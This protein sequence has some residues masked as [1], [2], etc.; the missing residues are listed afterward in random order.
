MQK[1]RL[2]LRPILGGLFFL[3]P[4]ATL[5]GAVETHGARPNVLIVLIDDHPFNLADVDQPSPVP[6]PNIRRIAARGTWF[7]NGYCDAP[8]CGPS[9]TALLTGVH[10]ARSGVYYNQQAYR[11]NTAFISKAI[12]LPGHFLAHG[13]LTA[14]YG[15]V[16]HNSFLM[17]DI[18][19]YS[20]GYYKWMDNP[21]D[22]T[23]T[24]DDLLNYILPGTRRQI[25]GV[26]STTWD[27]GMLPDDWDRSDPAKLQQ[28]T[29]QANRTIEMLRAKHDQPF[30]MV[31]GF[32]RPH[33]PWAVPK[34][35]FDQFPLEAIQ[36]PAG[37]RADDLEDLPKPGRW[38]ATNR[39]EHAEIVAAGMWKKC[40]Q[41]IFAATAYVDEQIGRV[42]DALERG[43]N[44][45]DTIVVFA[46]DNGFHTGEKNHW[47][48]FALWEQ[49]CRVVFAISVPG[50]PSQRSA[51][52]VGL[53][54]IYP[55]LNALCRLPAPAAQSLDGVDLSAIISGRTKERGRPVLSTYG[56][57]NHSLRNDRFRYIRYRNGA[58]E[59]YDHRV[60]G[61]EWNNLAADPNYAGA[62]AELKKWLPAVDAPDVSHPP[63]TALKHA[64]WEDEAFADPIK[65]P[66]ARAKN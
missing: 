25:P 29:E 19:D 47:L 34:R 44:A 23:H 36:L 30:F 38:I 8:S 3:V 9:R 24:N 58:E 37:Y 41:G 50:L 18:G 20:P 1:S 28:D 59:F 51:T 6:T 63:L 26:A 53:I 31:C 61:H 27:W 21:K 2:S 48:K 54:D 64:I 22:V 40:L 5:A 13:Y 4:L 57:G 35:Y 55:T 60:D 11:R 65:S 10:S 66:S 62:K 7:S 12:A 17:D 56:R 32:Y 39:G 49:T 46:A 14:G 43:P 33:I 52:P 45:N 16:A 15:K 42:L